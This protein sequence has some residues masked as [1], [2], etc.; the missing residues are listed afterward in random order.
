MNAIKKRQAKG[1]IIYDPKYCEPELFDMPLIRRNLADFG[2]PVLHIEY[3]MA[4]PFS[5]QT[6]TRI[7][8]FI[9][10]IK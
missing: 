9:E 8:A 7:N 4:E 3:D 6:L 1:L 10:M 5:Q 2:F